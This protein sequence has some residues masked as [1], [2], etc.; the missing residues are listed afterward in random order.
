MCFKFLFSGFYVGRSFQLISV[1]LKNKLFCQNNFHLLK[2]T[3]QYKIVPHQTPTGGLSPTRIFW[4]GVKGNF[5][6][7]NNCVLKWSFY[8]FYVG[9]GCF[10]NCKGIN[11]DMNSD[12]DL[13]FIP[14]KAVLLLVYFLCL[15]SYNNSIRF[16]PRKKEEIVRFSQFWKIIN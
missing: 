5:A 13:K 3:L 15:L 10:I 9:R 16:C 6:R 11:S 4:K 14:N 8:I 2:E 12:D 7:K 1:Y